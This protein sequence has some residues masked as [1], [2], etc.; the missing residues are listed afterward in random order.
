VI[1]ALTVG[2]VAAAQPVGQTSSAKAHSSKTGPRGPKGPA[3]PKGA[4]G[5][6]GPA[7]PAGPIGPLGPAGPAGPAGVAGAVGAQGPQGL[8]GPAGGAGNTNTTEFTYKSDT[9]GPTT[10]VTA[11]DGVKL[12]AS[13]D[14][15][16]RLTLI[17]VA[18]NVAP[19]IL[20]ERDGIAF[21]IVPRFGTAN[22]TARV[23][24]SPVSPA[25]SR[26]DVQVHYV[27]N[28]GQ[29]TSLNLAAVD[30]ADGPNGLSEAC[31]VFGTATTF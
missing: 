13:C 18:T 15:A 19:G 24:I 22:T 14:A 31:V 1:A 6:A 2:G 12:N 21:G 23:L 7:G 28:A 11:L 29:D 16:G 20:T 9:A 25:S 26:A 3:G 17:A 30:L 8:P 27:S 5:A 4:T 10:T